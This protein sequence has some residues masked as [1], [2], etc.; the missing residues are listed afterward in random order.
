MDVWGSAMYE[1]WW[2]KMIK[3]SIKAHE[4]SFSERTFIMSEAEPQ[5][6]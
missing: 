1:C 2:E 4:E 3:E 6:E 5:S